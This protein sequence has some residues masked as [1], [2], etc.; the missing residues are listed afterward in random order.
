MDS[1]VSAVVANLYI[2]FFEEL[3]M[4]KALTRP[5][6]W[7]RYVYDT[8]AFSGKAQLRNSFTISMGS[9]RLSSS[10]WSRKKTGHSFSLIHYSG[11]ERMVAWMSLSICRK[12][13]HMDRYLHFKSYPPVHMQRGVVRCLHDRARGIVNTQDKLQNEVDHLARVLKRNGYPADFI[14][15]ASVPP[16]QET[17]VQTRNRTKRSDHWW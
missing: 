7:K 4:G 10:R 2:E 13:M 8:F 15:N 3:A 6:L 12:P 11:E 16:T 1:L 5:R 17:A 9:G 14:S